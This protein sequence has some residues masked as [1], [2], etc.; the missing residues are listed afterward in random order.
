MT[1]D[2]KTKAQLIEMLAEAIR[3]TQ[4]QQAPQ[5]QERVGEAQPRKKRSASKAPAKAKRS[6][7]ANRRR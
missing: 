1:D 5:T 2:K 6:P 7:S 3:N 4:P